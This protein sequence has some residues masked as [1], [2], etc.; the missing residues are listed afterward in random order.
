MDGIK[1]SEKIQKQLWGDRNSELMT[2]DSEFYEIM[3]RFIY[4]EVWQHGN[5]EPKIRE[6]IIISVNITNNNME[7]CAEHV[8]AALNIGISPVEIKE[9]LYQCAPYVGF[10]KVQNAIVVTNQIFEEKG[11]KLPLENQ[12]TTTENNRIAKGI[13][14]QKSIFGSKNIDNLRA[15][16]PDNLKHIQDY[17]SGYCFGDICGRNGLDIK[18]RE[19][20]TFIIIATLGGC[21]NQLRAHIGGNAAIGNDKETLL[22][23]ITQCMPYI[24]FPRTLNAI[25][26]I[27]EVLK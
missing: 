15:N 21:E 19:L 9:T 2:S 16:A 13:E 4:G 3:K 8:E 7:Q 20:I 11:V 10:S 23:V 25:T 24:G 14:V 26:C 12:S 22:N 1:Y 18:I 17:L 5:L 27:N 6:L